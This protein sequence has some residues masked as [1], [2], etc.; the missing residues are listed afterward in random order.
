VSW[1]SRFFK[2]QREGHAVIQRVAVGHGAPPSRQVADPFEELY[3]LGRAIE[4]PYD[5]ES[6]A[7]LAE[8]NEVHAAALDA[9]AADAVGRGW[10]FVPR[11]SSPDEQARTDVELFLEH[12]NPNYT[13]SE[14]LY[15]AVWELRAVGWS[16]WE[17]VRADDGTIGAIYPLPA[18]TLRL[19]RDPNI[20]VQYRGGAFRYFKL[21][22]APFELDG[23]TGQVV[24]YTDDPAS[25]VIL[26]SRYHGR[27]RYGVPSWV[28]CIP[29]IVEYNAIRDY[30]VAFFDSSGA[31]GRIVHLSAPASVNLQDYVDQIEVALQEAVGRHRKTLVIGM[32][33]TVQFRVEKIGPD[34]QEASF[35]KRRE[36]LMKAILMAHQVPPYRV[37]LAVTNTFGGST[38]R[39]MMR[40]YRWGVIEPLQTVLED[41]LNKTLFGPY[42]LGLVLRGWYW[43]LEDLDIQ[44]TELDL[45]IARTGVDRMILTPNEARAVLGFRPVEH[46]AMDQFYF[47][48]KPVASGDVPTPGAAVSAETE[49]TDV[50]IANVHLVQ[51]GTRRWNP[52]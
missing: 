4:P 51:R 27:T 19:T 38:A 49:R 7:E 37:A 24:D 32:P 26:F 14:L 13:F 11:V 2:R 44:E 18:H 23:R 40:A 8:M 29:S 3:S 42:G 16:A 36:D 41:R 9:V 22:G 10:T 48:G 35:L 45:A 52:S 28:A 34:V 12:V 33:D 21:F 43:R 47:Q 20:F 31:V 15:Q 25:E 1:W 5:P 6:L 30:S 46:P 39:E 17:V 50:P